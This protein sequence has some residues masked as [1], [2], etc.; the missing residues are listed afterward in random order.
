MEVT[1]LSAMGRKVLH[2]LISTVQ[3]MEVVKWKYN[4]VKEL[5]NPVFF[6]KD[7]LMKDVF[8]FNHLSISCISQK[9]IFPSA[10]LRTFHF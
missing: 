7:I 2:E 1:L 6:C 9:K 10:P 8:G 4:S 3:G 5:G